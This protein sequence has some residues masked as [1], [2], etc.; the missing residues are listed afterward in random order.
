MACIY[1]DQCDCC[2]LYSQE[3][4]GELNYKNSCYGFS[5]E[6]DGTCAVDEDPNPYDNCEMFEPVDSG[7]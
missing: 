6:N 5:I 3:E 1:K 2:T 7:E 4:H